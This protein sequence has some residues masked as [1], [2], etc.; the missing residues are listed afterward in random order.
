MGLMA[1]T[2][3]PCTPGWIL[4]T[5]CMG[6]FTKPCWD[7]SWLWE[8]PEPTEGHLCLQMW[9][10][11]PSCLLGTNLP[12]SSPAS[13][14]R[15]L[16]QKRQNSQRQQGEGSPCWCPRGV[17]HSLCQILGALGCSSLLCLGVELEQ[18]RAED[19]S[20]LCHPLVKNVP[21]PPCISCV[22][23]WHTGGFLFSFSNHEEGSTHCLK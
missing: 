22:L 14:G 3:L 19:V 5:G 4:V 9:P 13:Q 15:R 11:H 21:T 18:P 12:R 1:R 2:P 16:K 20:P 23:A 7:S 6:R 10:H 17:L 8:V